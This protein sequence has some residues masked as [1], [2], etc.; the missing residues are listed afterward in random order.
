MEI[1][2]PPFKIYFFRVH[3]VSILLPFFGR[4]VLPSL[5]TH[6]SKFFISFAQA[7]S[8]LL[9]DDIF[10]RATVDGVVAS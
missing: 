4:C 1:F 3:V 8:T 2:S 10:I 7:E 9:D 6:Y 5:F